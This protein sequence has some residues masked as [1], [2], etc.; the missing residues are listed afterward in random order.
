MNLTEKDKSI[1]IGLLLGDGYIT[2]K[3]RIEIEHCLKQEEY[4]IYKAKLL[5]SVCGGT[6]INVHKYER[7]HSARKDGKQWKTKTFTTVSFSKQSQSFIPIREMLYRDRK[8]VFS[9]EVLSH[10]TPLGIALWWL[11]DGALTKKYNKG[12]TKPHY[13]LR[14]Y[15][16]VTKEE[17]ERIRD[18][19]INNYGMVWNVVPAEGK[20]RKE[21]QWML[22]CGQKEGIKFINI[23]KD[24]VNDKIPS[25]NYKVNIC[26]ESK[27][28]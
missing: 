16:Y 27:W 7:T 26:L 11:D 17:N 22:R 25:M 8:K 12:Y 6:D 21:N 2:D 20:K 24:I 15:T 5:H 19:F 9:D 13:M 23:I 14:L 18:Y 28:K 4:C 3:G 1:L 10:L